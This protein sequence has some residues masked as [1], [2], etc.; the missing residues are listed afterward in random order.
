MVL[1]K[2][3]ASKKAAL[4]RDESMIKADKLT[5][6]SSNPWG[7][8][9]YEHHCTRGKWCKGKA[10]DYQSTDRLKMGHSHSLVPLEIAFACSRLREPDRLFVARVLANEGRQQSQRPECQWG[11]C[12]KINQLFAIKRGTYRHF[13]CKSSCFKLQRK[14]VEKEVREYLFQVVKQVG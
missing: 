9:G 5:R 4:E 13:I 2:K 8:P 6:A 11:S 12:R 3:S 7:E 10:V 1:V 14:L